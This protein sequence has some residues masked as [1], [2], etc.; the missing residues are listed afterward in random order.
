MRNIRLKDLPSFIRTTDSNGIMLNFVPNEISKIPR[1]SAL[2][3]NT[4]DS[5]EQDALQAL[6]S[7]FSSVNLYSIGPLHVLS[8]DQIPGHEMKRIGSNPWKEDPECIKW[9]DLQE[10]NSVVYVNFGSIAVMTP[11]QL[12]E[13]A[14]GLAN[15]KKPFLWIKRPDLVISE[16]AV[17]SAEIL[18]EIKG[19]GILAS[20]CPQEQMLKHPSI[21][22]FLSHMGWNSTIESLSASVLL[23]CWP[24]F[25]EQQT[26]CKYACNEWGIGMEINDNV[27]REEVESLVRELM[28]GEKG[29]EMKK[30]AMDWKAKAEEATKPGGY[31]NFEEFLA[32]LK[33][34]QMNGKGKLD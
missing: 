13:F 30:K 26:N 16:S 15:S 28:E 25:A 4:F 14:W 18:I 29:K 19:R 20:W 3:L 33:N 6:S 23:L 27:K 31:Q 21:G 2:I 12:N 17:L 7:I 11:N 1:A 10:R 32:V 24:F 22:V 34:K 8:D 5:L 9:L